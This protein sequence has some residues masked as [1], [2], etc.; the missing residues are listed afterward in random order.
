MIRGIGLKTL[1]GVRS[2]ITL[3]VSVFQQ[4]VERARFS[5]LQVVGTPTTV[6]INKPRL[7]LRVSASRLAKGL[8]A[9]PSKSGDLFPHER[10][11]IQVI[12]DDGTK[13]E[14]LSFLPYDPKVKEIRIFGFG[15]W[16][17][18]RNVQVG[19]MISVVVE[20]KERGLYRIALDR[21]V[22]ERQEQR[23]R[24]KLRSAATDDA[25]IQELRA[26]SLLTNVR[27]RRTAEGEVLRMVQE[28]VCQPRLKVVTAAAARYE[29]VP[30]SV[31]IL[32]RELHQGRCQ[33]CGFT[34]AKRDGH[35]YFEIHHLDPELGH[36]PKNL[37]LLCGNCHAQFE[38]ANISDFE[39]LG[40]WLIGLK[41]NGKRV[42]VR[43]PLA[44]SLIVP[45]APA[46]AGF[47]LALQICRLVSFGLM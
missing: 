40:G 10:C 8:L 16:F 2:R 39:M 27:L 25:A 44:K 4:K 35:P 20:D 1:A 37:L 19:D 12:F 43:Q 26:L 6:S 31:R 45:S 22:R 33:V 14:L 11:Q 23:T 17:K 41:I 13:A 15:R 3:V 18:K 32:L 21:F 7:T 5:A 38:H 24:R 9:I 36:H 42:L 29:G 34:F 47:I 30:A 28:S 46:L